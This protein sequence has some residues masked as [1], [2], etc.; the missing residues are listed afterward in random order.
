MVKKYGSSPA[1]GVPGNVAACPHTIP[2]SL[3]L[4]LFNL[5]TNS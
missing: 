3:T 4:A 5:W 2:P 1:L